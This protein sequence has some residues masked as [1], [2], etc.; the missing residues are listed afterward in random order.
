MWFVLHLPSQQDLA[1]QKLLVR[2]PQSATSTHTFLP[3]HW[4]L[5]DICDPQPRSGRCSPHLSGLV[6]AQHAFDAYGHAPRCLSDRQV[7]HAPL[8]AEPHGPHEL[9]QQ[10]QVHL[11]FHR[12][13]DP[14]PMAD[15]SPTL[16]TYLYTQSAIIRTNVNTNHMRHSS[17]RLG[18]PL[19]V[20]GSVG[21]VPS[22]TV[23][24]AELADA[25]AI[26]TIHVTAW[27]ATYPGIVPQFV[28]DAVSI[29]ENTARRRAHLAEPAPGRFTLVASRSDAV[30]GFATGGPDRDGLEATGELYAIYAQPAQIG[31]G[32]GV[33][34]LRAVLAGLGVAG[35]RYAGLWVAEAN[36]HARRFYERFGLQLTGERRSI[37]VGEPV[38]ELRYG[39]E[40]PVPGEQR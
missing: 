31:T 5:T 10:N 11:P 39:I 33:A 12:Y 1:P 20:A 34:L 18:G 15:P 8:P 28:L 30:V 27:R 35:N 16:R 22:V 7:P 36:K 21:V 2:G 9:P 25:A 13:V 19:R 32:I 23:R 38:P 14:Q 4:C 24:P 37:D 6:M 26:A 3:E 29:E 40:L 17:H